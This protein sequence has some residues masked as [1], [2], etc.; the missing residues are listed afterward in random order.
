MRRGG[1]AADAS[2]SLDNGSPRQS[3]PDIS[4]LP[5]TCKRWIFVTRKSACEELSRGG[6]SDKEH[7]WIGELFITTIQYELSRSWNNT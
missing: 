7:L 6:I 2:T 3:R 5:L 4:Q 1:G